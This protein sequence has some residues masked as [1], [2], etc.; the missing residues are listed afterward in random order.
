MKTAFLIFVSL[1]LNST[2]NA[3]EANRPNIIFIYA[4][5]QSYKTVSCYPEHFPG[6]RTPNIDAL[7]KGGV[8]FHAAYL[9][10]W[11]M[12][13]RATIL[14]G[15]LPHG[16]QSMTMEGTY[17]G[18]TYDAKQCPFIPAQMRQQGYQTAQLGKWH[19][20]TDAGWGRDWDYQIVW[21]RPKHPENAGAYYDKQLLAFNGEERW[22]EGYPTDN[23]TQWACDYIKGAHR[24]AAKPWYLWL[25]YGSVHGPNIPA[26]RHRGDY[27]DLD[28]SLP[29]DIFPPREGKPDYLNQT[30][31]WTRGADG[32]PYAGKNA[33]EKVGDDKTAPKKGKQ[34]TSFQDWARRVNECVLALDEGVGRVM[35]ALRE[36]G[37]LENTLVVYSADQGFA[38]GE[39]G[40]RAKLA[41]YDANYRSP[42]IVSMPSRFKGG[43]V[44]QTPVSGADLAATFVAMSRVKIPWKLHGRDITPLLENPAAARPHGCLYEHMGQRYGSDVMGYFKGETDKGENKKFPPYFALVRGGFKLIHYLQSEHGEEL[45]DLRNDPDEL[46]NL[47]RDS[48]HTAR[49]QE[50]KAALKAELEHTEAPFGL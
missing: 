31:A 7:A 8:R 22:Q 29:A 4:D 46:K 39:H 34:G 37:Q 21:N 33:G 50:L 36:S 28:I 20:G 25:C 6:V 11:C 3:A 44:C 13:S 5:D 19:T 15:R 10:S 16:I 12:P 30:Q 32:Q 48:A 40:F 14:T 2:L 18:C 43:Q 26:E 49:M 41:P 24:D 45:Y 23:Y 1:L 38:M 27:S 9:G 47:V 42:L 35:E 17:P